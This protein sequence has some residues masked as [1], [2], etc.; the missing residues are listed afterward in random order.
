[1]S[2]QISLRMMKDLMT[3]ARPSSSPAVSSTGQ[4]SRTTGR[5]V[6]GVNIPC[7]IYT[8]RNTLLLG[9]AGQE[10]SSMLKVTCSVTVDVAVN[11]H[12]T[13]A[14]GRVFRVTKV[15]RPRQHH[16]ELDLETL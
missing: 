6:I 14:D 5:S 16:C 12:I 1:M 3:I 13:V 7:A 9:A 11:D 4:V 8:S 15:H 10:T 2:K